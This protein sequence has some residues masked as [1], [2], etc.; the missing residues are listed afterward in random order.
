MIISKYFRVIRNINTA[1][2]KYQGE[3]KQI[4]SFKTCMKKKTKAQPQ[5]ADSFKRSFHSSAILINLTE[6]QRLL[7]RVMTDTERLI[8]SNEKNLKRLARL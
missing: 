5:M 3:S 8:K 6:L 4:F 2:S 7:V 1:D